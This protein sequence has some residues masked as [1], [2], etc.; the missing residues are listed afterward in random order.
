[1]F[2]QVP[3]VYGP[4]DIQ[5]WDCDK[6]LEPGLWVP[7]RPCGPYLLSL[8]QR[9]KVAWRVFTGQLDALD[10]DQY[11]KYVVDDLESGQLHVVT[12]QDVKRILEENQTNFVNYPESIH[13][14]SDDC[15]TIF[16][17]G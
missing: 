8:W 3:T 4:T 7:A 10:W 17:T 2:N 5:T 15:P 11:P 6:E 13:W 12:E 1:M 16:S 9:L 14:T